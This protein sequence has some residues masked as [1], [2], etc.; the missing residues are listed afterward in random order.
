MLEYS[1]FRNFIKV[2]DKAKV[3]CVNS[4]FE[5]ADHLVEVTEVI[6]GGEMPE[7]LPRPKKSVKSI[8]KE[9]EKLDK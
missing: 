7:N 5:I 2:I 8:E 3:A 4:G 6:Q 9:Q 1:D